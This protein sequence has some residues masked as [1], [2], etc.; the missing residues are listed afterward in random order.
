[1]TAHGL[2]TGSL[3]SAREAKALGKVATLM[4]LD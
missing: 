2:A 4:Y 1:M 3:E